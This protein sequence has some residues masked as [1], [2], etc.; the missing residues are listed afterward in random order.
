[1]TMR[2]DSMVGPPSLVCRCGWKVPV[3]VRVI[4]DGV[5]EGDEVEYD[6]P[7]C[8]QRRYLVLSN[9]PQPDHTS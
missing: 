8:G 9:E 5:E 3:K 7:E 2:A 6:C 1:M 4:S